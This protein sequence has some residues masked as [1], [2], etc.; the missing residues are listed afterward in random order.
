MKTLVGSRLEAIG[1]R[2]GN[3]TAMLVLSLK[4]TYKNLPALLL[5]ISGA[6]R[7][8]TDLEYKGLREERAMLSWM[9]DKLPASG[10][11]VS[12]NRL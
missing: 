8:R 4:M 6:H 5:E 3:I 9:P 1:D 2:K 7:G 10:L 11:D 12:E